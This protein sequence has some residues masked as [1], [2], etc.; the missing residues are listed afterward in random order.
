MYFVVVGGISLFFIILL[1]VGSWAIEKMLAREK[2]D[3]AY[4]EKR[5]RFRDKA[6]K[7]IPSADT[8]SY[9]A[10]GLFISIILYF[11]FIAE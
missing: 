2:V 11:T 4:K 1:Y 10:A 3:P 6:D 7:F 9:I 5:D 8:G